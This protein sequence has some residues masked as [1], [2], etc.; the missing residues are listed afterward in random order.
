MSEYIEREAAIEAVKKERDYTGKFTFEEEHAWAVGF[1]QGITF[2]LSDLAVIPASDVRPVVQGMWVDEPIKGIRY[3]CSVCQGR[4]DY[5]WHF[6]PNCGADMRGGKLMY[7]ELLERLRDWPRVCAQYDGSVDQLHDEAADAIEEL[8]SKLCDWC[9]VC[10]KE[11]RSP[12]DCEIMWP[13]APIPEVYIE[14]PK[15]E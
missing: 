1:Q 4:F 3:H 10:P 8:A 13:N 14:P 7:N 12:W 6:C 5:T 9:G 11:R 2:A 15:E